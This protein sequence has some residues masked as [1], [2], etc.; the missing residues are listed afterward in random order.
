MMT[1]DVEQVS[2]L[3]KQ[4]N[5]KPALELG[6]AVAQL[7][8]EAFTEAGNVDDLFS[9]LAHL[10]R[11][12]NSPTAVLTVSFEIGRDELTTTV[13]VESDDDEG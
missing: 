8:V 12:K 13:T 3:T 2:K 1:I 9:V 4:D 7:A 10:V 11:L 5:L 6:D